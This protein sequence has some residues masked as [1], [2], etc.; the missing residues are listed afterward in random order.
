MSCTALW[1]LPAS[2]KQNCLFE[3][4]RLRVSAQVCIWKFPS[5]QVPQSPYALMLHRRIH[6][7][8]SVTFFYSQSLASD[9]CDSLFLMKAAAHT[10]G[11]YLQSADSQ[12]LVCF[13]MQLKPKSRP[14]SAG[15]AHSV[16]RRPSLLAFCQMPA[17]NLAIIT[18]GGSFHQWGCCQ[19]LPQRYASLRQVIR[20]AA[21]ITWWE[22]RTRTEALHNKARWDMKDHNLLIVIVITPGNCFFFTTD[23]HIIM[24]VES[25]NR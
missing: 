21:G 6:L 3:R 22:T 20:P 2:D 12:Q 19:I 25:V 17:F 5:T 1:T 4:A 7:T 13:Y 16:H 23:V 18:P 9:V 14:L 24:T 11:W 10:S 15:H 8:C